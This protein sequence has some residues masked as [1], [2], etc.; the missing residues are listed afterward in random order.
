MKNLLK[1]FH[2]RNKKTAKTA[3]E[4]LQIVVSHQRAND[5]SPEFL[6][7]LRKELLDVICKYITIDIDQ[8]NVN[9]QREGNCSILE[10]NVTIPEP[11]SNTN[12]QKKEPYI[13]EESAVNNKRQTAKEIEEEELLD[14]E[15]ADV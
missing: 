5:T 6:P 8:I 13:K 9:L 12:Q 15:I 7:A 11:I 1:F 3:K 10:L 4:R 2:L 14:V